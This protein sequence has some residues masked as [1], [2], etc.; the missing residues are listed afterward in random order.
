MFKI[1]TSN[2]LSKHSSFFI[3]LLT[4]GSGFLIFILSSSFTGQNTG[5][6][7]IHSEQKKNFDLFLIEPNTQSIVDNWSNTFQKSG[8]NEISADG[9][10][11][12]I[13][14]DKIN[15]S[16]EFST[17][18]IQTSTY[19]H[20]IYYGNGVD[21]MNINLVNISLTGLMVG[22][23]L[24]VFD[25]IYCVGSSIIEEQN[26]QDN[27]LSIPASANDTIE[28][29]PNGFIEGHKITLKM[30]RS[31]VVYLLSFQTVNESQDIF[32]K[33]ASMFALIDLSQSTGIQNPENPVEF[34]IFPNPFDQVIQIEVYL[35]Q[36]QQLRCEILDVNGNLVKTLFDGETEGVVNLIW[37]GKDNNIK[38]VPS[39][40]YFCRLNQAITQI[41]YNRQNNQ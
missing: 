3:A 25:G 39:G 36:A 6:S 30:Y 19:F 5:K 1:R 32:E 20:K 10:F 11:L 33:R 38:L 37:D 29:N 2:H 31:G 7:P 24:G 15:S 26:M 41:I 27:N 14:P 34:R 12:D 22:D 28:S 9:Y 35:L 13:L 18:Y 4:L 21:H 40:V 16:T 23:E 17:F 8:N